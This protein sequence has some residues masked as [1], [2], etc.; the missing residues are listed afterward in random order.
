MNRYIV[1]LLA[2]FFIC[3]FVGVSPVAA[4][5]TTAYADNGR[6]STIDEAL[7][8]TIVTND[9]TDVLEK[10]VAAL[11]KSMTKRYENF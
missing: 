8:V 9:V 7:T 10:Y 5:Y 4:D 3:V 2:V 1:C 6:S 11:S